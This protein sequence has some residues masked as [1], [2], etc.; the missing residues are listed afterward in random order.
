MAT[1]GSIQLTAHAFRA[2]HARNCDDLYRTIYSSSIQNVCGAGQ[3]ILEWD[4]HCSEEVIAHH[5]HRC[6]NYYDIKSTCD[7]NLCCLSSDEMKAS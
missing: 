7:Q 5:D 2:R 3:F 4:A 1:T 6:N